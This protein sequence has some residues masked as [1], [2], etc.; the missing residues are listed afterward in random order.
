[1][2]LNRGI[3]RSSRS[4]LRG[5]RSRRW[6]ISGAFRGRRCMRGW[7]STRPVVWRAWPTR[8]VTSTTR[9]PSRVG[10]TAK[11]VT[12]ADFE[13]RL[14]VALNGRPA[15]YMQQIERGADVPSAEVEQLIARLTHLV[16]QA[17][18]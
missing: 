8:H 12:V 13:T 14:T 5:A 10:A 9:R 16:R 11:N 4:S 1:M 3:K 7:R 17:C 18:A 2:W 15:V 6:P